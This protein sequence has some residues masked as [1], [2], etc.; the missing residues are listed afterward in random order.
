[1]NELSTLV[2]EEEIDTVDKFGL[3]NLQ[4]NELAK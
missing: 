2:K 4:Q 3:S 1:L